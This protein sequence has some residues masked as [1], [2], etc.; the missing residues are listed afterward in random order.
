MEPSLAVAQAECCFLQ[1]KT[2]LC[3]DLTAFTTCCNAHTG[4]VAK[5]DVVDNRRKTSQ[6][7][8]QAMYIASSGR[9]AQIPVATFS[10]VYHATI[11]EPRASV[12]LGPATVLYAVMMQ[13]DQHNIMCSWAATVKVTE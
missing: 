13:G 12:Q 3:A 6:Q 11:D 8:K 9:I 4:H 2:E 10:E 5:Q 1:M 7:L